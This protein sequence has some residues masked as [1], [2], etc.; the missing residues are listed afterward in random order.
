MP[1]DRWLRE[2][3]EYCEVGFSAADRLPVLHLFERKK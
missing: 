3:G 1:L 2:A